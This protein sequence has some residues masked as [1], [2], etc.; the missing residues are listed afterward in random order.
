MAFD[1]DSFARAFPTLWH[2]TSATNWPR[3]AATRS[4]QSAASLMRAAGD[5]AWL[6]RRREAAVPLTVGTEVVWLRDQAP[7]HEGAV[8][9]EGGWT[10]PQLVR[11]INERVYFWPG[12]HT[13]PTRKAR[14]NFSAFR[15]A[16]GYVLLR[17]PT[18][19]LLA[20]VGSLRVQ[21][22]RVNVGALRH[23]PTSGYAARGPGTFMGLGAFTGAASAVQEVTVR[24]R[25]DLT[26]IWADIVAVET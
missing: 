26:P 8:R 20:T 2:V 1:R 7:L 18:A 22:T 11:E 10:F 3:I 16:G 15:Q 21:L 17:V 12:D 25:V 9:L 13:G 19:P 24:D 23:H 4:L 6:E 14:E 5:T